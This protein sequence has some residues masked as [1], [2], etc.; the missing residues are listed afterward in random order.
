MKKSACVGTVVVGSTVAVRYRYEAGSSQPAGE[1]QL[2]ATFPD[3]GLDYKYGGWHLTR[4]IAI[5]PND[6]L[7]AVGGGSAAYGPVVVA[8][9]GTGDSTARILS[10]RRNAGIY[11]VAFSSDG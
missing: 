11:F 9:I 8:E 5:A 3:Y 10:Q 7:V 2:L 6:A 4:S 1:P